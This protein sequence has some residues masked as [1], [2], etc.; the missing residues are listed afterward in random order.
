MKRN[1]VFAACLMLFAL[2]GVVV[3]SVILFGGYGLILVGVI[4]AA[5]MGSTSGQTD[6]RRALRSGG[7]TKRPRPD[8]PARVRA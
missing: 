6:G 2:L 1:E 3:G 8:D 5:A 7:C 4:F